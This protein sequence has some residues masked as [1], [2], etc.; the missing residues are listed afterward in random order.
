VHKPQPFFPIQANSSHP[1][2]LEVVQDI[3]LK[4]FQSWLCKPDSVRFIAVSNG[5]DSKNGDSNEF[6]PFLNSV[7]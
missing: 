2:P 7:C 5:I 3:Q 6:A 1:Q 4:A